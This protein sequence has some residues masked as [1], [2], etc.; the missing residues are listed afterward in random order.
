MIMRNGLWK[1]S[2]TGAFQTSHASLFDFLDTTPW[3]SFRTSETMPSAQAN[4]ALDENLTLT[5]SWT[6][7]AP[8]VALRIFVADNDVK[9]EQLNEKHLAA[10]IQP[11][12]KSY[13]AKEPLLLLRELIA[14]GA[15]QWGISPVANGNGY[16]AYKL[17][18]IPKT[19]KV[20]TKP[21]GNKLKLKQ[22][23]RKQLIHFATVNAYG[24][25][26]EIVTI[27]ESIPPLDGAEDDEEAN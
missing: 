18:N 25:M 26:S 20:F 6:P 8:A 3:L 23:K 1:S 24:E 12:A 21:N 2:S 15:K 19:L 27:P 10:V 7:E 14:T 22:G 4:L 16:I 13:T 11:P 5:A 9:T 17:A